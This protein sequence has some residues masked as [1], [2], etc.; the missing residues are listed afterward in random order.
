MQITGK[1]KLLG[2]IGDPVEHS[3]SP[4]I[5]NQAIKVLNL[6]Y[7]YVPFPVQKENLNTVL[8]GFLNCGIQGFNVTIP[9]KQAIIPLLREISD[10]A[11]KIGAVNTVWLT[12]T[13]WQGT[14]TDIDG[15]IAPLQ[16]LNFDW[17]KIIPLVL[18]NGGAS[19]AVIVGCEKLGCQQINVIGRNLEKLADFQASWQGK[20]LNILINTHT[21]DNLVNLIPQSQLIVNTTPIG[22]YPQIQQSPFTESQIKLINQN[23][24]VYDLI[25]TPSPTLFLQQA[26]SQGTTIIDGTEMLLQQGAIAF[27]IW[28]HQPAP[29]KIMREALLSILNHEQLL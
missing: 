23:A 22:M 25:Y 28:T 9:H 13:G 19:R 1:T 29:V 11:R 20:G 17:T 15:F 14:N 4:V 27:E 16:Q 26:Q 10:T 12:E 21:W 5:Q 2:I 3:L 8:N 24:I 7:I 6:D 18:G